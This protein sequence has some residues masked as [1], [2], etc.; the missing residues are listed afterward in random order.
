MITHSSTI[1]VSA[2]SFSNDALLVETL[3]KSFSNVIVN[4]SGKRFTDAELIEYLMPAD[5]AIIGIEK[6]NK[7][8]LDHLPRLKVISKFGVG[9]DNIDI[10][11]AQTLGKK[12]LYRPGVNR[13]SVAELA[14]SLMIGI[15]RNVLVTTSQMRSG[16]WEKNGG[17]QLSGKVVGVIGCGHIGSEL[18]RLLQ[19]FGCRLLVNDIV[20][21]RDLCSDLGASQVELMQLVESADFISIHTPLTDATWH[22]F[23]VATLSRCKPGCI[24]IN[25][26]RGGIV[27]ENALYHS[28]RDRR[29]GAAALDVFE[30]EPLADSAL[31]GLANFFGTPHIGG[32]AKEAVYAMGQAAIECL[33]L[34]I[35]NVE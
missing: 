28:L 15:A 33:E 19:P 3:K 18:L 32:N 11:Y 31:T 10:A 21:K 7:H 23:D 25:T 17:F 20:D 16:I 1:C 22:L 12:V 13:R 34:A 14:L 26:A 5:A 4:T 27:D 24:I 30:T 35:S 8:V 2:V 9:L 6:L 29:I